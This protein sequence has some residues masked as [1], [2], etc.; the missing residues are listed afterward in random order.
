L[1]TE[2]YATMSISTQPLPGTTIDPLYPE[3][4]GKPMG[5]TGFHVAATLHLY[6][7]LGSFFRD[8]HDV[9]VGC[10]MFVYYERG[11]PAAC[12]GPDVFVAIGV[13]GN[14]Q[15]RVFRLWEEAVGPTVIIEVTSSSTFDEDDLVKPLVYAKLGVREYFMFDPDAE[16]LNPPLKGQRLRNGAYELMRPDA[17]G[18]LISHEL[19]L[20]LEADGPL[21]RAIDAR[22]GERLM[23]VDEYADATNEL[24]K[25]LDE[26]QRQVDDARQQVDEARRQ[27]EAERRRVAALEAELARLRGSNP[28]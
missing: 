23:N 1:P 24:R 19:G 2:T 12:K 16:E 17:E 27:T 6:A 5:E 11:N 15:R 20:L 21:L 10:D 28:A 13:A 22:T 3:S 25:R 14:H 8:R 18:R 9:F 26:T 7:V 4:D